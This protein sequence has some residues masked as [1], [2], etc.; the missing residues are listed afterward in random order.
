[1]VVISLNDMLEA[2]AMK[3]EP[4]L[5]KLRELY[6]EWEDDKDSP[7]YQ[8]LFHTFCFVSYKMG[9]FQKYCEEMSKKEKK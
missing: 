4:L 7:E 2:P 3:A 9:D 6:K 1:M 5:A 8:A